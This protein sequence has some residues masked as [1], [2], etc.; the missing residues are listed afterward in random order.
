M[1]TLTPNS[2]HGSK[3]KSCW[4]LL[5]IAFV[6]SI[7]F[8]ASFI[9]YFQGQDL[10][11]HLCRI[12]G[13]ADALAHGEFPV[14][15]QWTQI[16]GYG[17]PVS[18]LYGD[19]FLYFPAALYLAGCPILLAYNL[20]VI[21]TNIAT[22]CVAYYSFEKIFGSGWIPALG[23][24]LWTLAPYRLLNVYVR[25]AV[26]EYLAAAFIPLC[27]LGVWML[28]SK[29]GHG[30]TQGAV[31][32]AVGFSSIVYSHIISAFLVAL[33][34]AIAIAI[35][36]FV[37]HDKKT[38]GALFLAATLTLLLSAAFLIPFLDFYSSES[39]KV[40]NIDPNAAQNMF[41]ANRLQPSQLL[42]L[43]PTFSGSY[44]SPASGE[45]FGTPPTIGWSIAFFVIICIIDL[46]KNGLSRES[47]NR[48]RGGANY[49]IAE[50]ALLSFSLLIYMATTKLFPWGF[51]ESV[52]PL[53][54]LTS[55]FVKIQMPMRMLSVANFL[56][57]LAGCI[58]LMR[59][60]T[61]SSKFVRCCILSLLAFGCI[62]AGVNATSF[63][64]EAVPLN[65]Y[66][67]ISTA[68]NV[69]IGEYLPD[70]SKFDFDDSV[71]LEGNGLTATVSSQRSD[72]VIDYQS[73]SE[74]GSITLPRSYYEKYEIVF[75]TDG[76]ASLLGKSPEG[77]LR[78]IVPP[79]SDGR[80]EIGFAIP[81]LWNI[82]FGLTVFA[83]VLCWVLL[84]R[85]RLSECI[86]QSNAC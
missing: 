15:M 71:E 1:L 82:A 79:D 73:G 20:F 37:R 46:G 34:S 80:V 63:I 25:A 50:L 74:T 13:I 26:G 59:L 28:F 41:N 78:L 9:P 56:L 60:S 49:A 35:G 38:V 22:V 8:F 84:I 65:D 12:A 30:K 69:G 53:T 42:M 6:G 18:I 33:V 61:K 36:L 5:L 77:K 72:I 31:I 2:Q 86:P 57:I 32:F 55:L 47:S 24:A 21:A 81:A 45:L 58:A 76:E 4:T 75:R 68:A 54:K 67:S 62:Q 64:E 66:S 3:V 7:P 48:E 11:F 40:N 17:Y 83:F 29:K 43:F 51:L 85:N 14:R 44:C 39:L 10:P 19:L 23:A 27:A 16:N 52:G 70:T